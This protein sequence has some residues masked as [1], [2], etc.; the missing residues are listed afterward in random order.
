MTARGKGAPL[1]AAIAVGSVPVPKEPLLAQGRLFWLEQRPQENGRTTLMGRGAQGTPPRDLTPGP[2]NLR[3]RIHGYGGGAYGAGAK[4]L[5]IKKDES[6]PA[7][8]PTEENIVNGTYPI[9]RYLYVY[10]NPA[11]DKGEIG[12]YLKWIRSDDGQKTVKDVGYFPLP[13]NRR[14]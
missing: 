7:I 5:A 10:V 2:W 6:S 12:A 14:Q 9:W 13:A 8:E 11:L 3:S 4:H 1:S